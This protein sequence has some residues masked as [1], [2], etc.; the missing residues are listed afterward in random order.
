[1]DLTVE[2]K[3]YRLSYD[4][5]EMSYIYNFISDMIK[6]NVKQGETYFLTRKKVKELIEYLKVQSYQFDWQKERL[7]EE[8]S[9]L[10]ML[11]VGKEKAS[12]YFW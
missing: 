11:M 10:E 8:L 12:F 2:T 4:H 3:Q 7:I 1:M 5:L 9:N 6:G